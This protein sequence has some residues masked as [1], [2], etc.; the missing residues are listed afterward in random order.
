MLGIDLQLFGY[1]K[2]NVEHMVSRWHRT[3]GFLLPGALPSSDSIGGV[4]GTGVGS[5]AGLLGPGSSLKWTRTWHQTIGQAMA[6][7]I[8]P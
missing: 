7:L 5:Y 1:H 3:D 2:S 8:G 6:N 4:A